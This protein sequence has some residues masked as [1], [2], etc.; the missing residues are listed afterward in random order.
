MKTFCPECGF[1]VK[2]D[3]DGCCVSCGSVATGPAVDEL[4][5]P[6]S[7]KK[8]IY[9]KGYICKDCRKAV[10]EVAKP[11]I[12]CGETAKHLRGC[13]IGSMFNAIIA[14]P[15]ICPN[16]EQPLMCGQDG[17]PFCFGCGYTNEEEDE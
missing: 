6:C 5:T 7:C 1:G 12:E 8:V 9:H 10:V 14:P 2:V 13:K 3:E 15:D 11:C 17:L 16:C 4:A